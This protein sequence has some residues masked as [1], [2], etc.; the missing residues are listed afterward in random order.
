MGAKLHNIGAKGRYPNDG[1]M[2][3]CAGAMHQGLAQKLH[4]LNV[5][6]F[7]QLSYWRT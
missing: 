3:G 7:P 5:P 2:P 6:F 4:F 1:M